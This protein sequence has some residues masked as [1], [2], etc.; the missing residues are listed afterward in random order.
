MS[1]GICDSESLETVEYDPV[2]KTP[3]GAISESN[4]IARYDSLYNSSQREE[5]EKWIDFSTFEICANIRRCWLSSCGFYIRP[6]GADSVLE[7]RFR[8]S[9]PWKPKDSAKQKARIDTLKSGDSLHNWKV[10]YRNTRKIEFERVS[11]G[12]WD[13]YNPNEYSLWL[14]SCRKNVE[15]N[16]LIQTLK[17]LGGLMR[18]TRL[19]GKDLFGQMLFITS[20]EDFIVK[21]F[22]LFRGPVRPQLLVDDEHYK[23]FKWIP[24]NNHDGQKNV[25]N[26]IIES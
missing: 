9:R 15:S 5:I 19:D 20:G 21:G 7:K 23:E 18:R 4:A 16:A 14:C 8:F 3:D 12:F 22:W 24:Y 10:L 17:D 13:M 11:K 2:R 25:V 1:E 26:Q 6:E